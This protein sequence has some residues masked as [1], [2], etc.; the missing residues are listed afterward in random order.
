MLEIINNK[1]NFSL[2]CEL[3]FADFY[4]CVRF[5]VVHSC[6]VCSSLVLVARCKTYSKRGVM[7]C[8][9]RSKRHSISQHRLDDILRRGE[10][11]RN[12]ESFRIHIWAMY[13]GNHSDIWSGILLLQIRA[14]NATSNFGGRVAVI[15]R[16]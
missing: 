5:A 14:S 10:C 9:A 3:F 4:D 13:G 7:H 6:C 16:T 2:Y 11:S 8:L 1:Q 15:C 12:L